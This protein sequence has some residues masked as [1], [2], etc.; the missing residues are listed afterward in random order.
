ML[1][2]FAL[3]LF[4]GTTINFQCTS[5]EFKSPSNS[6][7][8]SEVTQPQETSTPITTPTVKSAGTT[9]P[10]LAK[11]AKTSATD[12]PNTSTEKLPDCVQKDCNCS[13]FN[14]QTQAQA[15]LDAFPN[16][17]HKLDKNKDGRAC[18]SLP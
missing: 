18:E 1:R 10:K 8:K 17:P 11:K 9:A 16:D 7:K 12:S 5:Q 14:T 4:L 13:D 15:V 3:V 6:R 2:S